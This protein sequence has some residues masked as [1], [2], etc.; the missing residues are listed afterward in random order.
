MPRGYERPL[1]LLPFDHRGSFQTG[2]FGWHPP[3]DEAQ[4]AAVCDA[5]RIIYDGFLRALAGGVPAQKTGILVDEQFGAALLRDAAGRGV[6]TACPQEKS[7]RN[8]FAFEYGEDFPRHVER[9]DPTF[10]KVLVRYNPGGDRALNRRQAAR[11]KRLSDFLAARGRSRFLFELLVPAE[12]SQLQRLGG[13]LEAYDRELR[14][15]LMVEAIHELQEAG[16]EPDL[17]KVEGLD[18]REDCR[19]IV[20]AARAGGR[21]KVGCIVL[22]RG[23]DGE[24]VREWLTVAAGVPG[25]VGFAIGR[26]VFWRPLVDWLAGKATRE[27]AVAEIAARFAEFVDLF[28]KEALLRLPGMPRGSR[29]DQPLVQ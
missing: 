5:K 11:L 14:P 25:F 20:A 26:T 2:L 3:L 29:V 1:Y 28:E 15:D 18:S 19:A 22:G 27:R 6:A 10:C 13:D 23:A 8:E 17:W 9:F 21:D 16:V 7:G 12:K 4:T 24:K